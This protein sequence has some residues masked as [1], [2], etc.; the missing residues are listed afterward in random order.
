MT[1]CGLATMTVRAKETGPGLIRSHR[2]IQT[3]TKLRQTM[4]VC[5]ALSLHHPAV[6]GATN[7]VKRHMTLFA[8]NVS[9]FIV[10]ASSKEI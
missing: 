3:G 8:K 4:A 2:H 9:S 10:L 1:L 5:L 6:H 7:R